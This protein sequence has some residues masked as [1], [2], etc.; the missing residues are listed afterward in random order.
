MRINRVLL[1]VIRDVNP[2]LDEVLEIGSIV[3][4]E[5][6]ENTY[7][8][9]GFVPKEKGVCILSLNG[10]NREY[11]SQADKLFILRAEILTEDELN[12]NP[13]INQPNSSIFTTF[14]KGENKTI[15]S[16]NIKVTQEGPFKTIII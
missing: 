3:C 16:S 12:K 10:S 14:I 5:R 7:V 2:P 6:G 15:N 11:F 8:V 13:F 9:K 1:E 4:Y